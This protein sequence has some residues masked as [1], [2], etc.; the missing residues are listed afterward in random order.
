MLGFSR[1][2]IFKTSAAAVLA[3]GT[4]SL[5]LIYF[6]PAPPS[7]V[8][9]ATAFKGSSFAYFG[10][11]YR[12]IFARSH[13]ELKLRET[14]G[15]VDNIEL[16]KNPNSGVQIAL[17]FGGISDAERAPGVLSLGIVYTNPFWIFYSSDEP[18]DRL[19]QL[20]GK[21]IAVGPVGSGTRF[22]AERILGRSGVDSTTTTLLPFGGAAAVT[23]LNESK[24]DVVW[25][26]GSPDAP[27]VS[28]LLRNPKVRLMSFPLADAFTRVFPELVR[29]VLP[30]GVIDLDSIT[31]PNDVVLVGTTVKV[32]VRNDLHPQIVQVLLQAMVEAHGGA[33]IFQRAG[34]FPNATDPEYPVAPAASDFYKSG[35]SLTQRY[36]PLWLSVHAQRAIA[37]L[38]AGLAIGLPTFRFL[39]VFYQWVMRRRLTYWYA[40]LKALEA[41]FDA[42]VN[43]KSLPDTN[44]E[45]ERIEDA[46]SHI[47]FPLTFTDQLYNLRSHIDIVRRKIAS[48][49]H[50]PGSMAAE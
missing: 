2:Q 15:A 28:S 3:V 13:V 44:V 6:I 9:M 42:N 38:V 46:V 31:P 20:K 12:D 37:V 50:A 32:L 47:R 48:R 45:I 30:Q 25:I 33:N 16:L 18:L 43:A 22:S 8:T 49:A 34:E 21:R 26:A 23:A 35:P 40:K 17:A 14:D 1:R 39:P 5:L 27:A 36:L 24:V 4:I 10:Q 29:L 7:T 11:R 41:S 19:S